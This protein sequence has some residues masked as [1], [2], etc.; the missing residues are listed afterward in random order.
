MSYP[1][2]IAAITD[3]LLLAIRDAPL[4]KA[5]STA[6]AQTIGEASRGWKH[7]RGVS[8][9]SLVTES[10]M[11]QGSP[12]TCHSTTT[13]GKPSYKEG[14][15]IQSMAL[16][17]FGT[18]ERKPRN[19]TEPESPESCNF[20]LG[21]LQTAPRRRPDEQV[22]SRAPPQLGD[23]SSSFAWFF[24]SLKRPTC[25]ITTWSVVIPNS[26]LTVCLSPSSIAIELEVLSVGN[27][28]EPSVS[29]KPAPGIR[30][31][32]DEIRGTCVHD[33]P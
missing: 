1:D 29:E 32:C 18:S 21:R 4:N 12:L 10:E 24:C 17:S 25:P 19:K 7:T 30:P 6:L 27:H 3:S 9:H 26:V 28:R 23:T 33:G 5:D 31:A 14:N 8:A 2:P 22:L 13:L 16:S 20:P 15:T 11:T